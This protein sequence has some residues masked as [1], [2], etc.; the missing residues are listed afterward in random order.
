MRTDTHRPGHVDHRP[1]LQNTRDSETLGLLPAFDGSSVIATERIRGPHPAAVTE[2]DEVLV[3]LIHVSAGADTRLERA[4]LRARTVEKV[5][6]HA[7]DLTQ[8]ASTPHHRSR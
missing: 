6:G 7:V 2:R 4:P 1:K 3:E 8:N 5:F